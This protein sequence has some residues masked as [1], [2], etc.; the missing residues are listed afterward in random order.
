M[1]DNLRILKQ[2]VLLYRMTTDNCLIFIVEIDFISSNRSKQV[3]VIFRELTSIDEDDP[4]TLRDALGLNIAD[5]WNSKHSQHQIP[6]KIELLKILH[7]IIKKGSP[8]QIRI[9]FAPPPLKH[10]IFIH[11][12]FQFYLDLVS[13]IK[14]LLNLA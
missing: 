2:P 9:T 1:E 13:S 3:K 14:A 7:L 6:L 11:L 10:I 8:I 4:S 12:T 5:W